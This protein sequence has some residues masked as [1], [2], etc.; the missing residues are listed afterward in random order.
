MN[1]LS[2]KEAEKLLEFV[3]TFN[4]DEFENIIWEEK[5]WTFLYHLSSYRKN[6]VDW[7]PITKNMAVLEMNGEAG[8]LTGTLA[9]KAGK[10]FC[11]EPDAILANI[12]RSRN[13]DFANLTV[14]E[15]GVVEKALKTEKIDAAVLYDGFYDKSII[16]T[17]A[18]MKDIKAHLTEEGIIVFIAR[19]RFGMRYWAGGKN[20]G[21]GDFFSS[22][23]EDSDKFKLGFSKKEIE[24]LLEEA[25]FHIEMF[26]YPHP[27]IFFPMNI[28][29][30]ERLPLK[31]ELNHNRR[32][33]ATEKLIL[34]EEEKVFDR[35]IEMEEFPL[36]S[37]GYIVI[38]S[39]RKGA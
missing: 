19:N 38:A 34:F 28:Y 11:M 26:Y 9:K 8:A 31:G 17:D 12:N 29:S 23:S 33:F 21:G 10:V 15:E 2:E 30:D 1:S 22:I 27:D 5:S 13:R 32:N 14:L 6:V 16:F 37:N 24:E 18:V 25:G 35:M 20:E 7:L 36:F 4:E 3:E 39:V